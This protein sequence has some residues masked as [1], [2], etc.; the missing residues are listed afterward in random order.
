M[1]LGIRP[2]LSLFETKMTGTHSVHSV[3]FGFRPP[4]VRFRVKDGSE[5][6][7]GLAWN[8]CVQHPASLDHSTPAGVCAI[9]RGAI[10]DC[11]PSVR[12]RVRVKVRVQVKASLG[13]RAWV[14]AR[15]WT[16]PLP[17]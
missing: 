10:E 5:P 6:G 13:V 9:R 16:C 7:F 3:W 17:C 11:V 12:V 1:G 15:V 4:E 8:R 14:G 2:R